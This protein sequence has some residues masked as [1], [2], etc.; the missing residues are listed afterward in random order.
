[1]LREV[2]ARVSISR[3]G[4]GVENRVAFLG[5]A[6]SSSKSRTHTHTHTH[7]ISESHHHPQSQR[8]PTPNPS[9]S[10]R[11]ITHQDAFFPPWDQPLGRFLQACVPP[12]SHMGLTGSLSRETLLW[13]SSP[14]TTSPQVFP[15]TS[16]AIPGAWNDML[17][18]LFL[19]PVIVPLA[20]PLPGRNMALFIYLNMDLRTQHLS[21]SSNQFPKLWPEHVIS[22]SQFHLG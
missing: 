20:R 18:R 22:I 3:P 6:S 10:I 4:S 5:S 16:M 19:Q 11:F 7:R 14:G 21:R 15:Q 12:C 8:W 1:M 13:T 17:L 2:Q 9:V